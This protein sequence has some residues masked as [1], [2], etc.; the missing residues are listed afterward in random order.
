M[1]H[2]MIAARLAIGSFGSRGGRLMTFGS[3]GSTAITTTPAAVAKKRRYSTISG[4]R[5]TPSLMSNAE[6]AMNSIT[7]ASSWVIW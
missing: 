2:E 7:R 5:A 3:P 1:I 6:A 4:V